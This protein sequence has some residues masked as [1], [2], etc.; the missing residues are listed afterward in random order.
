M[1]H[2]LHFTRNG[3][4]GVQP[5]NCLV[6]LPKT[7][8]PIV[9]SFPR[10]KSILIS[11]NWWL[12][13]R[14]QFPYYKMLTVVQRAIP[15]L[16]W[17]TKILSIIGFVSQTLKSCQWWIFPVPC[18]VKPQELQELQVINLPCKILTKMATA[19]ACCNVFWPHVR[20]VEA[21][22]LNLAS[23]LG[24]ISM[25]ERESPGRNTSYQYLLGNFKNGERS[26]LSMQKH[27]KNL[28]SVRAKCNKSLWIMAYGCP[29]DY[30]LNQ[31]GCHVEPIHRSSSARQLYNQDIWTTISM[32]SI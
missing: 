9:F 4:F 22:H 28:Y 31:I 23:G 20:L 21:S 27:C 18:A 32:W 25:I 26:W 12:S 8:T 15:H 5:N 19:L 1:V 13:R 14:Q 17:W 16:S 29:L 2:S 6:S 7:K 10:D 30:N 3:S 11:C 24:S